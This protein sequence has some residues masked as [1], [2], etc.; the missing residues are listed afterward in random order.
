[1]V[2]HFPWRA[3]GVSRPVRSIGGWALRGEGMLPG[4]LRLPLAGILAML[5]LWAGALRA[6]DSN[7]PLREI[8]VPFEDLN[9]IL[10]SDKQRVF[11]T[12]QEYD[13]LVKRAKSQPQSP[14][15]HKVVLSTA[16]YEG[17]LQEGRALITGKLTFEVLDEGLFALPLDLGGVG[18]RSATLDGKPAPLSRDPQQ[19]PLVLVQG[20]GQHNLELRLTAPLQTAAAQQS[21]NIALPTNAAAR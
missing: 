13:D 21:L 19:R 8:F 16:E 1:M 15:P 18:I 3:V 14:A 2:K 4:G 9:V 10:D 20:K 12:R 17:E 11:L 5:M 6:Q 7:Q